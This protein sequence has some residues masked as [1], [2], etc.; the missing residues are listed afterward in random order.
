MF[1]IQHYNLTVLFLFLSIMDSL[2]P[3]QY[4]ARKQSRRQESVKH[5]NN[6]FVG[7]VL[8][9]SMLRDTQKALWLP[10]YY[11]SLGYREVESTGYTDERQHTTSTSNCIRSFSDFV[12]H[13]NSPL[14]F[15]TIL[16]WTPITDGIME[17]VLGFQKGEIGTEHVR[18]RKEWVQRA[19]F[20]MDCLVRSHRK[21][22]QLRV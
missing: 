14:Y 10:L 6:N 2:E 17:S 12:F 8:H 7:L 18:A 20:T 5:W 15:H 4:E 19:F 9:S 13:Q 16:S 1:F 11:S 21:A 3:I 22:S